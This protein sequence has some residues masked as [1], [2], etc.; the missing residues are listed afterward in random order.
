MPTNQGRVTVN[1]SS[2]NIG[3][4]TPGRTSELGNLSVENPTVKEM[5]NGIAGGNQLS[6]RREQAPEP[7]SNGRLEQSR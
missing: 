1:N 2:Q 4:A 3:Q 7:A 6:T 5:N